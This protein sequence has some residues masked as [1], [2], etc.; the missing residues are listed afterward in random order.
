M[1]RGVDRGGY[2]RAAHIAV[3]FFVIAGT[4]PS[5]ISSQVPVRF[6]EGTVHGFLLLYD[7]G[8]KRIAQ[9]D[10]L[11]TTTGSQV[12]A[13]MIF[14]F[15]D[16]SR[17]EERVNYTQ[18]SVFLLNRYELTQTGPVFERDLEVQLQRSTGEYR[19]T[20]RGRDKDDKPEIHTGTMDLPPD[21]ANGMMMIVAKNVPP[22]VTRKVHYVAFMPKP[23]LIEL[24]L[25]PGG[26]TEVTV[27]NNSEAVAHWVIKPDIGTIRSI[28]AK[29]VG[30]SPP[31]LHAWIVVHEVPAFVRFRGPLFTGGPVW[32][33]DLSSPTWTEPAAVAKVR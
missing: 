6:T 18:D 2:V 28:L 12:N 7:A 32:R 24:S 15:D 19:V 31:D 25:V 10:L 9:G 4:L 17:L 11:Q 3:I 20:A 5:A 1:G 30:K 13:R 16:G 26:R 8:G 27:G 22:E 23:M 33:I 14:Q 21:V 29:L